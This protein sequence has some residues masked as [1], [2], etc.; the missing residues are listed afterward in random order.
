MNDLQVR[1]QLTIGASAVEPAALKMARH[2]QTV[3]NVIVALAMVTAVGLLLFARGPSVF[4]MVTTTLYVI[5]PA[6]L[7]A[8]TRYQKARRLRRIGARAMTDLSLEWK[9]VGKTIRS[10]N[11]AFAFEVSGAVARSL[12][13]DPL[14]LPAA[15]LVRRNMRSPP[16]LMTSA[17]RDKD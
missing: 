7:L 13:R 12:R 1:A 14:A 5:V 6:G 11:P 3:A 2:H 17:R 8:V 10:S 4:R 15:T 16:P 9:L